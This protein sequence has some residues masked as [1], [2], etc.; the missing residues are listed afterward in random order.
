MAQM[1]DRCY[2]E[3]CRDRLYGEFVVGGIA[4]EKDAAGNQKVVYAS[5]EDLVKKTPAFFKTAV[6]RLESDLGGAYNYAASHFG[7]FNYYIH[8][9]TR[10]VHFAKEMSAGQRNGLRRTPPPPS[11]SV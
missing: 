7:G 6:E 8:A 1:A 11:P 5:G 9:A 2:L 4:I 3:K 10:N